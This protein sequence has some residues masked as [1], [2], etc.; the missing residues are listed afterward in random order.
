MKNSTNSNQDTEEI[1]QRERERGRQLIS[2]KKPKTNWNFKKMLCRRKNESIAFKATQWLGRFFF[3]TVFGSRRTLHPKRAEAARPTSTFFFISN[4]VRKTYGK[5][6]NAIIGQ[7]YGHIK[8]CFVYGAF[9][10]FDTTKKS[11]RRNIRAAVQMDTDH[12]N[13]RALCTN[14]KLSISLILIRVTAASLFS[15]AR[16]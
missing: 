12:T 3:G 8:L 6:F 5:P 16:Y 4:D 13:S 9:L 15:H 1:E 10:W 11:E 2:Q 7:I 14:R